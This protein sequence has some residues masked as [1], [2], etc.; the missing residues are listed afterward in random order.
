MLRS[1]AATPSAMSIITERNR[2]LPFTSLIPVDA[3]VRF[4][5]QRDIV[6]RRAISCIMIVIKN[7][8]KARS[9][10]IV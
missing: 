6:Q 1:A 4:L 2:V 8:L 7:V 9:S 10:L 5:Y 3:A